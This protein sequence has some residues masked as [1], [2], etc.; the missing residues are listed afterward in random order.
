MRRRR[1]FSLRMRLRAQVSTPKRCGASMRSRRATPLLGDYHRLYAARANLALK[2]FAAALDR[3]HAVPEDSPLDGEAR[4]ARADALRQFDRKREAEQEYQS[5][6]DRY[7]KSW[8]E[9]EVRFRLAELQAAEDKPAGPAK[10]AKAAKQGRWQLAR[11]GYLQL[12]LH[13]PTESWGLVAGER[14]KAR[15]PAALQLDGTGHLERGLAL[16]EAQRNPESEAELRAALESGTLDSKQSCIAA[17]HLAQSVFKGRQRPRA[18]PLFDAAAAACEKAP[19][20]DPQVQDLQV[21]SLYQGARCHAA[22]G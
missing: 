6:L 2:Q 17:F 7:P 11:Q 8:R 14:L 12:Y 9:P 18:A 20:A 19:T 15:E 16:F 10:D 5:Y 3:A 21:K 13:W 22:R 4:I 1:V